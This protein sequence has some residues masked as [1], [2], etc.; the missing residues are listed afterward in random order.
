MSR[1]NAPSISVCIPAFNNE[2]FI[3]AAIRSVLG[4]TR[5][6]FELIIADDLSSDLTR[7]KVRAFSDG[8]IR[9][10]END[11]NLGHEGNWNKVLAEARGRFVKILPGD[12]LLYPRCLERQMAAFE[13]PSSE[14]IAL[15][16]CARDVIDEQGRRILKRAFPGRE[17]FGAGPG[18]RSPLGS[19]RNEPHRRTGRGP[20][21]GR[22]DRPGGRI[23]RGKHLCDR[24]GLLGPSS[25][26]RRAGRYSRTV[27]RFPGVPVV[28]QHAHPV[29]PEPRFPSFSRPARPKSRNLD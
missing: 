25:S 11:R 12:D 24:P 19:G 2:R 8:R 23:Q 16:S 5:D 14:G 7:E 28:R 21:P 22:P 17:S 26:A 9:L 6:D 3:E 27:V 10:I 13:D 4:Q 1:P 20:Y 15:V 18:S 29:D